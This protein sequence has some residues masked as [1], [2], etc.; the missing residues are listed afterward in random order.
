MP[1]FAAEQGSNA[2]PLAFKVNSQHVQYTDSHIFADYQYENATVA[3]TTD[4]S[5][6]VN[7]VS[8]KYQFKTDARVPRVG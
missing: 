4:G 6:K 8:V 3:K 1:P 2:A 7:P 5:Y